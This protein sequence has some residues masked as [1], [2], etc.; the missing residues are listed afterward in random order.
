MDIDFGE[1]PEFD[2]ALTSCPKW[3]DCAQKAR[4]EIARLKIGNL[5]S[6]L[7]ARLILMQASQGEIYRWQRRLSCALGQKPRKK[8]D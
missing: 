8:L 7:Y 1:C 5:D 4:E 6:G 3:H 2:P